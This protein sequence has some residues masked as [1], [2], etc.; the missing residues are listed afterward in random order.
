VVSARRG[1]GKTVWLR[2]E[3]E[4]GSP[5]RI[6]TDMDIADFS[7]TVPFELR[8]GEILLQLAAGGT[9]EIT[10]TDLVQR[11]PNSQPTT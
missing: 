1:E 5:Y 10:A 11:P 3:S 9:A 6:K 8:A 7:C 4:A 2:I